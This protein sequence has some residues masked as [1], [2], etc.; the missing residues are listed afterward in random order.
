MLPSDLKIDSFKSYPS[1]ARKIA[2]DN[3]ASL[4]Q[5]PLSF[6]P[7][8]L[9]EI[10]EYDY[11][12]PAERRSLDKE[13][14]NLRSLSPDQL[15]R[16]F[17]AFAQIKLS[18]NLQRFDWVNFPAQFVEQL[19]PHLWTTHKL[20]A[21]RGAAIVYADKLRATVPP[22]PPLPLSRLGIAVIGQGVAEY[23]E[24][25]FRRLRPQG[26]YFTKIKPENGLPQ[27]L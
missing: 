14:A 8:M 25:L 6:L 23:H 12:F 27:L 7:G 9:R 13:V 5:L 10:I 3:L 22:E 15:K 1:E 2:T 11:K 16:W 24:A 20:D 26:A 19:S 18:Q 17:Q 4:R 21:F